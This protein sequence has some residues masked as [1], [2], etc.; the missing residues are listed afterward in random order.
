MKRGLKL[1]GILVFGASVAACEKG[2]R[3][4]YNQPKYTAYQESELFP[5]GQSVRPE[6]P[7]T[8]AYAAGTFAG[9]SSGREGEVEPVAEPGTVYPLVA[10]EGPLGERAA[11]VTRGSLP[12]NIPYPVT[13][14]FINEGRE[15]FDIYCVPCHGLLADG[16]GILPHR[17]FPAPPDFH[18]ER[19]R[20]APDWHFYAVMSKGYGVM[21]S[22]ADR[23]EP[24]QR[25]AIVAYIRALQ[26]SQNATIADVPADARGELEAAGP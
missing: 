5:D 26:L 10:A 14:A 15:R 8:V 11:R 2:F 1:I 22:Y 4:M 17:G 13:P 23:I 9:T 12:E 6:V 19:L 20:Q 16:E 24:R 3:D 25:W 21:Y 7:G 18:T